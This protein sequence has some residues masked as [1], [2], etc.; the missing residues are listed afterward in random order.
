LERLNLRCFIAVDFPTKILEKIDQII[1][2]FGTQTPSK[3]IKW[4]AKE[5]LHL[6]LKFIG[7]VSP[8]Q[9]DQMKSIIPEAIHR[10]SA[11]EVGIEGLGMY[12]SY[13][14]PRVVWL[15]ITNG[16]PLIDIHKHLDQALS[17][18]NIKPE[19]R[20]FSPHL[21]IARLRNHSKPVDVIRVGK[22]LSQFKVGNLGFARIDQIRLYQ[23]ELK[24]EGPIYSPLMTIPLNQV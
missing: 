13:E 18:A 23:S 20:P 7:E 10:K 24:P 22:Q 16:Q 11:F 3:V 21:T 6:T 12:P 5:N 1:Q 4:V 14:K 8:G 19:N 17:Q 2:Y 9:L 15:G